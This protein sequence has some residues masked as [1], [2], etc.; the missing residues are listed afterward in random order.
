MDE[1]IIN[2]TMPSGA[3]AQQHQFIMEDK[4]VYTN[5]DIMNLLNIGVGKLRQL[6]NEGYLGY[7]RYPSSDKIWYTRKNLEDFL[8]NP[9]A[10]YQAWR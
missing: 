9:I 8:N 2:G 10:Q 4:P 6:R 1:R 3:D 5:D 7:V